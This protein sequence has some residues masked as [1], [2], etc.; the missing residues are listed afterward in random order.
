MWFKQRSIN[1]RE[2]EKQLRAVK[3]LTASFCLVLCLQG[4]TSKH[5]KKSADKE[6]AKLIGE[7]SGM[8]PNMPEDFTIVYQKTV[9]LEGYAL[10]EESSEFFGDEADFEVGARS[11]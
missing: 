4:C 9:D 6:A 2:H 8:V 10:Q 1:S 11:R 5:H 7:K 3:L